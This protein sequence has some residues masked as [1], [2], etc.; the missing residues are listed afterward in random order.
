MARA[1]SCDVTAYKDLSEGSDSDQGGQSRVMPAGE[2]EEDGEA[3]L[4]PVWVKS[5]K[6]TD[7]VGPGDRFQGHTPGRGGP[8]GGRF[9]PDSS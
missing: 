5:H 9:S 2:G 8:G 1:G 4:P 6:G 7:Q 3:V